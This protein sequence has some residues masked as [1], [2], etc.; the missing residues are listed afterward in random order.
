MKFLKQKIGSGFIFLMVFIFIG[1]STSNLWKPW[2]SA[3][4]WGLLGISF[5]RGAILFWRRAKMIYVAVVMALL[6]IACFV[7]FFV[8]TIMPESHESWRQ[9]WFPLVIVMLI[10]YAIERK[11]NPDKMKKW[12]SAGMKASFFELL[13]FKYIADLED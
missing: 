4:L 9:I 8:L 3:I 6:S 7:S 13:W 12:E 5:S 2:E 10:M 1:V 11:K